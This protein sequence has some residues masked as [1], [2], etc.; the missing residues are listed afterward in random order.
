MQNNYFSS[1]SRNSRFLREEQHRSIVEGLKA[2]VPFLN[3]SG[4]MLVIEPL[5]TLVDHKGY[6][7]DS[8][9][10]GFQIVNEVDSPFV[11]VLYDIY[12]MQIMEGNIISTI[13]KNIN[14][15]GYFHVAGVPG[16]HEP[17]IGELFYLNIFKAIKA[18]GFKGYIALEYF[19][20]TPPYISLMKLLQEIKTYDLA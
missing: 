5:N 20:I 18:T 6:Y 3:E 14:N 15:I 11:K 8:S 9:K 13:N 19:P 10:E 12:H 1:W 16:R 17:Y 2:C 4:I 7:L